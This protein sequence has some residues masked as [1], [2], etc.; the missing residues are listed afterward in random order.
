VGD[1]PG[2]QKW[3]GPAT[4][5]Q[6]LDGKLVLPGIIDSHTH[7]GLVALFA[8]V[9]PMPF[10][11]VTPMPYTGREETLAWL[12]GFAKKNPKLPC[13][14]AGSWRQE[15]YGTAGP[16][17]RDLDAIVSDRP[18]FLME[19]YGHSAWMNSKALEVLG[20]TRDTP[21]PV[22]GLS[23]F[24]RD[25]NGEP[26]GW[27]KEG[28]AWYSFC[29]L[30]TLGEDFEKVLTFYL[31]Y[32][33]AHGVTTLFDAGNISYED[34]VYS[35]LSGLDQ[36]G[37]LPLR[38]EACHHIYLPDQIYGAVAELKRLR[39]TYGGENLKFNTIK[40]H[41]DGISWNHTAALMESY[42]NDS[43][44]RGANLISE[45]RLADF[46]RE[47]HR[48][49]IDLHIHIM[50]DRAAHEVLNAYETVKREMGDQLYPRLTLCHLPLV[51]DYDLPRFKQLGVVANFTPGW[52]GF[53]IEMMEPDVGARAENLFRVKPLLEDGVPVTF[54]SDLISLLHIKWA[55]PFVAMQIGHNRQEVKGGKEAP[56]LPPP[57]ERLSLEDMIRGYTYT[58]AYQLRLD[59]RLGSIEVG[60]SADL[61][62]LDENLFEMD[63]YDIHETKVEMTMMAGEVVYTRNW[64]AV[65]KEKLFEWYLAYF[66]WSNS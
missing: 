9:T 31:D 12:K 55:N 18:V 29:K 56:V 16:H 64:K 49:K 50:G 38:Y 39:S 62:V 6:D 27:A 25:A 43:S 21:D 34:E 11:G 5:K 14:V 35:I 28:S 60:K 8:G 22:P 54:S 23:Y 65:L 51:K 13:I 53:P 52:H 57:T 20:V 24:Q 41:Q 40:I 3:I 4:D 58:G 2:I 32:L 66:Y 19:H 42:S 37:L 47:L 30:F 10:T 1:N 36:E 48:E 7:P 33:C 63:R 44:E 59:D 26:T 45:S 17:K 61:V 46:I 15:D